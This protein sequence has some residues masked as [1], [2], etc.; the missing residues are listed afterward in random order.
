M[1]RMAG[2]NKALALVPCSVVLSMTVGCGSVGD[3][4]SEQKVYGGTRVPAGSWNNVVAITQRSSGMYCSGTAIAPT[5]VITAAHC[6]KGFSASNVAVYV[7]EGKEGGRVTG[8][9]QAKKIKYSPKYNTT[10]DIAYIELTKPLDLEESD[11]VPVLTDA[12]EIDELLAIGGTGR[13]VGFGNR[14]DGGFGVKFEVD[15]KITKLTSNEITIGGGGKDSCQGDSGGPVFGKLA[16]GEWRVYGVTSRGGACGTGGIY[17]LMHAN[18]CWV[19]EDSGVD[20]G[21]PEGTCD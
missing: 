13:I 5:V 15:G 2:F 6:I 21:L 1:K 8:Q 11:Y 12:D 14:N 7:G 10:N 4:T 19:Q 17:G 9:Y 16:N 3:S 18:I 20:L